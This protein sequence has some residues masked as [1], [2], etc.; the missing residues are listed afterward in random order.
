MR[1][2]ISTFVRE[3]GTETRGAQDPTCFGFGLRLLLHSWSRAGG[4]PGTG[5]LLGWGDGGFL[6]LGCAGQAAGDVRCE[7]IGWMQ[8]AHV[9]QHQTRLGV[10]FAIH[11]Y[12][13]NK[14]FDLTF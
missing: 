2:T 5:G 3:G 10:R 6:G 12:G 8:R 4:Y 11:L 9:A 7:A 14:W 13:N 1:L